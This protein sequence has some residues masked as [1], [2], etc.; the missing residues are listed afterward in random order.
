MNT[1]GAYKDAKVSGNLKY[2]SKVS[3]ID[4]KKITIE[5]TNLCKYTCEMCPREKMTRNQGIMTMED[6]QLVLDRLKEYIEETQR[7][8]PFASEFSLL[9]YG[10]P[11]FD[12]NLAAKSALV[13]EQFPSSLTSIH[14]TMGV[15]RTEAY[16]EKLLVEAKF[17]LIV[18][19]FY[20]FQEATYNF[21][22]KDGSFETAKKNLKHLALINKSLGSPCT[23]LLQLLNPLTQA[24]IDKNPLEKAAFD[25]LMAFLE[26]LGVGLYKL[27]LHNFGNGREYFDAEM[28]ASVCSVVD[29]DR[30]RELNVTWDLEI[31][32]CCLDFN[33][34]I[35]LGDLREQ[36]IF[37]IY[38]GEKYQKFIAAH[39]D[40]NL[41]D[42]PVCK[43][44]NIR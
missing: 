7:P 29:G 10:E 22:H 18:V 35:V 34:D 3:G 27:D 32:P 13:T 12:P 5:T 42:Y 16:L 33:S 11:L 43:G 25:E 8:Q 39:S 41:D 2:N 40:G 14:S 26:P 37:E 4:F 17:K 21:V 24:V 36:T 6:F 44:C 20:G 23:I 31:V 38:Q 19:S 15:P 1:F 9:G 30:R 28:V